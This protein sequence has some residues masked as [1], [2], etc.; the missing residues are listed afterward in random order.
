[1]RPLMTMLCAAVTVL[2]QSNDWPQFRGP[3]GSGVGTGTGYPVEFNPG[4]NVA[5]KAAVPYGQS[6]PVVVGGRVYVTGSEGGKLMTISFDAKTGKENW[7][8][9]I[10]GT[11]QQK[12]YAAN[13]PASPSPAA[14]E[15]GVYVFFADFG[16]A[17]YNADGSD[18]WRMPLGPF[19]NFYGM[20]ASPIVVG[21]TLIQVLDQQS[22]SYML[23][24]DTKSGKLKWKTERKG[25]TVGWATPMVFRPTGEP[26]QLVVL[27]TTQL[28]G[29]FLETGEPRWFLRQSSMGGVGTVVSE[30]DTLLASTLST[31]EPWIPP[32]ESVLKKYDKDGNGELSEAEFKDDPDLGGHF[33][34]LD[35][36]E[37][38]RLTA[39]EWNAT[40]RLI[41]IGDF[42]AIALKPGAA[43]GEI[44]TEAVAW[45]FKRNL[46]YVAAPLVYQG[47]FYLLKDGGIIT[48]LD[49]ATGKVLKQGRSSEGLGQYFSS[50]V[51]ADGKVYLANSEG[52][53]TV[54]TAGAQWE[55]LGV[56]AMGDD[57]HA[58][59]ALSNGRIYVRTRGALYC[60]ATER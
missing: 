46:P 45:R 21:E 27:G 15:T 52:K 56:N 39:A 38:R 54:L 35:T 37:D 7:R 1:M 40:R 25:A 41:S 43:K 13:D 14:D 12:T 36:N 42:G 48:S 24:I 33:G 6:S 22:G 16:L 23:A 49:P 17:A 53:I 28:D 31:S 57:V 11:R 44:K 9:E 8:R 50:P 5:W 3:N 19:K 2:A 58:T 4:K 29:Y 26:A 10:R 59:P 55:V 34:W 32:F 47:V 20:A 18:R 60:F 30:G 51:A